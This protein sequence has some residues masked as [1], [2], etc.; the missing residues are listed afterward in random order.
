MDSEL[1]VTHWIINH[2]NALLIMVLKAYSIYRSG[3][4][5]IYQYHK[6]REMQNSSEVFKSN[7]DYYQRVAHKKCL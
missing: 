6:I 3:I 2:A 5:S 1:E 4:H 7:F